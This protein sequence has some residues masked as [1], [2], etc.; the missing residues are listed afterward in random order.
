M[1]ENTI[2]YWESEEKFEL[3]NFYS[4]SKHSKNKAILNT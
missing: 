4:L 2:I 3:R 1:L